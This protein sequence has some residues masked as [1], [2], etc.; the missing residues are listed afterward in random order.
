MHF[1]FFLRSALLGRVKIDDWGIAWGEIK[2]LRR[3]L[4]QSLNA[5][6]D[7]AKLPAV[8]T[9]RRDEDPYT[10]WADH[11]RLT[12]RLTRML[13]QDAIA[14]GSG[15]RV[16]I[17]VPAYN[18]PEKYLR[19]LL[20]SV[21]GQLYP[22]WELCIVDDAARQPPVLKFLEEAAKRDARIKPI[23]RKGK[24]SHRPRHQFSALEA[25]TGDYVAFLDHDDLLPLDALF[26]CGQCVK[27]HAGRRHAL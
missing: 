16:S 22:N 6:A 5:P 3:H 18:T 13:T 8:V 21:Q 23:F 19:E 7:P 24:W 17:V 1:R 25:A 9:K 11:N 15:P 12:P 26:A 4:A 14:L 27:S 2:R 20:A 10:R